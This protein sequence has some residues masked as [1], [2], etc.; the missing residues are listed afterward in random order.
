[1]FSMNNLHK[2]HAFAIKLWMCI[3]ICL[4]F[5]ECWVCLCVCLC[6]CVYLY[7]RKQISSTS[8]HSLFF[9]ALIEHKNQWEAKRK[10]WILNWIWWSKVK[11][12]FNVWPSSYEYMNENNSNL[13][14][15][16]NL[17]VMFTDDYSISYLLYC[18]TIALVIVKFTYS[19]PFLYRIQ[20]VLWIWWMMA[21]QHQSVTKT[22]T[23]SLRVSVCFGYKM[24]QV[25]I[26]AFYTFK[27]NA[28]VTH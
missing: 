13:H 11:W 27:F 18:G 8:S 24:N 1:M 7:C 20:N 21:I 14:Y 26:I 17:N 3:F 2:K 19:I 16:I 25:I 15:I 22:Y 28:A 12:R 4:A 5:N 6:L 9:F 10:K 23:V